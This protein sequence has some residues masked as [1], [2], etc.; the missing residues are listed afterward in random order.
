MLHALT[1]PAEACLVDG[2]RLG[3]TAPPHRAVV[4]GDEKSAAIAAASIVAKVTRDRLMRRF[5]SLYPAYG[6]AQRVG[7]I[8]P[9]IP[10]SCAS[11]AR[12]PCTVSPSRRSRSAPRRVARA[13]GGAVNG[14]ERRAARWYRLAAGG[15]SAQTSGRRQRARLDRTPGASFVRR[16]QGKA[17]RRATVSRAR[18]S[19]SRSNAVCGVQPETWLAARPGLDGLS[20]G[21]DVVAVAGGRLERLADAFE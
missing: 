3:P 5:D 14:A 11:E 1:P 21:F 18:R 16:G 4:D 17:W 2:F 12:V 7:Y 6:F 9:V 10:R 20:V 13:G 15:S 19:P 8:T